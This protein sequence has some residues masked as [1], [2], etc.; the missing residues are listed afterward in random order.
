MSTATPPDPDGVWQRLDAR[1]PAVRSGR[2][3][4]SALSFL[5][6]LVLVRRESAG[7]GILTILSFG[8]VLVAFLGVDIIRWSRTSFR[9]GEERIELRTGLVKL[10]SLNVPRDRV[11]R[12]ELTSGLLHRAL[13]VSVLTIGTGEQ[14]GAGGDTITL[15]ALDTAAA[16][17]LRRQLLQATTGATVGQPA[18][19]S[20][21]LPPPSAPTG[22]SPPPY[23]PVVAAP[24]IA[25][26][27]S[28]SL[29]RFRWAWAPY[30]LLSWWTL[31]AP[32]LVLASAWQLAL[33]AGVDP[34]RSDVVRDGSDVITTTPVW[35]LVV[36]LV[37]GGVLVGLVASFVLFVTRWWGYELVR[38][39]GDRIRLR[40]GLFTT[41]STTFDERRLRGAQLRVTLPLRL[42][43][44]GRLRVIAHGLSTQEQATADR[45]DALGPAIPL[46]VA[47]ALSAAVLRSDAAPTAASLRPHPAGALAR[48]R[49][50]ALVATA[51]ATIVA[52]AAS[53]WIDW[54]VLALV[55]V[56]AVTGALLADD[57]YRGLGHAV[58]GAFLVAREGTVDRRTTALARAG[59][60]GWTVRQ[61]WFQRRRG[62]ATLVATT[63]AG[64]GGYE[65][66]D[67][68]LADAFALADEAVPG[69]LPPLLS[70]TPAGPT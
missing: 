52:V 11:R 25:P 14:R 44:G 2:V 53:F 54:Y 60:I 21:D 41:R 69:L 19:L 3:A 58:S 26:V 65:V 9:V 45:A 36:V 47:H 42:A 28:E 34:L 57:A 38:E 12:V 56:V 37:L 13:G 5:V 8:A 23:R 70:P 48:R 43:R 10:R 20:L 40:R 6:F 68:A 33:S 7:S 39:P 59:I 31:A 17:E 32:L 64:A 1:T 30:D 49:I 51:L 67:L 50:R 27:A 46:E 62:L 15:D 35:I 66:V 22:P 18:P 55:P 4:G 63:A 29:A 16:S 24:A 61:S